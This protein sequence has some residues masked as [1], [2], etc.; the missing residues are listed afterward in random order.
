MLNKHQIIGRLGG[1]PEVRHL[2]SGAAVASFSVATSEVWKD[3]TTGEKKQDVEWHNVVLWRGLAEV[4]E[5]HLTKGSLV[6][7]SGKKKTRSY[8]KEGTTRYVT[9]LVGNELVMLDTR[10][11]GGSNERPSAPTQQPH[12]GEDVDLLF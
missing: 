10:S 12:T 9:D 4:A 8:K 1:D 6:Y 3:K 11:S 7:I 5:K 2:E